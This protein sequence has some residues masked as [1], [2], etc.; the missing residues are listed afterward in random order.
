MLPLDPSAPMAVPVFFGVATALF[1]TFAG[2]LALLAVAVWW[3]WSG[4]GIAVPRE[5]WPLP[6]RALALFGWG[7]FIGGILGQVLA[8]VIHVGVASW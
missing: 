1:F 4:D 2:G 7:C 3:A 6:I 5:R 8:H